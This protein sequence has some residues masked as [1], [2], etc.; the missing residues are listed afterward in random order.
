MFPL[1]LLSLIWLIHSLFTAQKVTVCLDVIVVIYSLEGTATSVP[2]NKGHN[3]RHIF[4]ILSVTNNIDFLIWGNAESSQ[5]SEPV[6]VSTCI[7]G[8]L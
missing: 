1:V 6:S 5:P 4:E 2:V 8:H 7:T 3:R